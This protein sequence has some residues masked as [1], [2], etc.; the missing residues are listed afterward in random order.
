MNSR[1][2]YFSDCIISVQ[3]KRSTLNRRALQSILNNTNN[4]NWNETFEKVYAEIDDTDKLINETEKYKFDF[5]T[6][7]RRQ[8]NIPYYW[9]NKNTHE[10][11]D[12][13]LKKLA[14]QALY[15]ARYKMKY[16]QQLREKFAKSNQFK[17][18]YIAS[19]THYHFKILASVRYVIAAMSQSATSEQSMYHTI[20]L[21]NVYYD[22]D[23]DF[24]WLMY[25][26]EE[27][28]QRQLEI[29]AKQYKDRERLSTLSWG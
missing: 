14:L 1:E 10:K 7:A 24:D 6:S 21:N 12:K 19:K 11:S 16:M 15:N 27:T 29:K 26:L 8:R 28:F 4:K 17:L 2:L 13:L 23:V 22:L 20:R 18:G 3:S 9:R 5:T 25:F